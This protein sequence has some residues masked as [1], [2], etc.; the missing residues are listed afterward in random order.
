VAGR[1]REGR[2]FVAGDAA[3]IHSPAGGQGM[4]TGIQDTYNLAW[5]IALVVAG[6]ARE[7]LLD[8]YS[9]ERRP[10]VA[11]VVRGSDWLTRVVTLRSPVA[12]SIRN[13]IVSVLTEF[14]FVQK[15]LSRA[16]SELGIGYRGSPIVA[17]DRAPLLSVLQRPGLGRFLDFGA[18]PHPGDRVPDVLLATPGAPGPSRLFQVLHGTRHTLLL[19]E[20]VAPAEE[21]RHNLDTVAEAA[22]LR[23]GDRIAV[24]RVTQSSAPPGA[25]TAGDTRLADLDGAL[26]HR[27]GA[28]AH[29]LYLIRPDGYVGYRAQPPDA[30]LL[31][32]YLD[33]ML[34]EKAEI[35]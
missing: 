12:E 25:E 20:G 9:A 2:C 24:Y 23:L 13:H 10:V 27:F 21:V 17:E 32:A 3:H 14:D 26:H 22:R 4:N 11:G 29:C 6:A 16:A 18:A 15:R 30:G 1:F 28:G 34:G 33:H 7:G 19:F 35:T 8:S 31:L 5:K